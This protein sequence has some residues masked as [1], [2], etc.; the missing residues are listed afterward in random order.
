MPKPRILA[1][2]Q[3]SFEFAPDSDGHRLPSSLFGLLSNDVA[4]LEEDGVREFLLFAQ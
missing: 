3:I 4:E 2:E 1:S